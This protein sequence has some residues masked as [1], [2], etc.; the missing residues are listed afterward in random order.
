M[1]DDAEPFAVCVALDLDEAM[2]DRQ[3]ELLQAFAGDLLR[4][5]QRIQSED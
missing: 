1:N 2:Q 5:L 4:L 3:A